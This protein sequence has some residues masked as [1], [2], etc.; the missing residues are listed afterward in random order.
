[1]WIDTWTG[2]ERV[3]LSWQ[4]KPLFWDVSSGFPLANHL[5][6]PI[7]E[8]VF[9]VFQGPPMCAHISLSKMNSSKEA[10]G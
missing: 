8:S 2:S 5:A 7:S 1:M 10:Q 9:G 4:F 6:L 3:K